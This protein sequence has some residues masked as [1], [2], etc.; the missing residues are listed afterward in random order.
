V[1]R[2]YRP[3]WELLADALKRVQNTNDVTEDEAKADLCRALADG[4]I[5]IKVKIADS[6]PM[7]GEHV[8]HPSPCQRLS[9]SDF[10][11]RRST[12]LPST[13][14]FHRFPDQPVEEMM[15]STADV[16]EVLCGGV[17]VEHSL[18]KRSADNQRQPS[19][20]QTFDRHATMAPRAA[21]RPLT[22]AA[23]EQFVRD[24]VDRERR[25]G[26][27]PTMVG[28]EAEIRKA[29]WRGGR[30]FLRA[31]FKQIMGDGVTRGRPRKSP[32]KIAKK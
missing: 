8:L 22:K 12:A 32:A 19:S 24:S 4:K 3:D 13:I 2:R 23:A 7:G 20:G 30:E 17:S 9:P 26:V 6:A 31:A 29:G 27:R 15:V 18:Q 25:T 10:D 11:W 1:R 5:R 21:S 28:L 16:V 14:S